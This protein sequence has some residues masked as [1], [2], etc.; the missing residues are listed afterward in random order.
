MKRAVLFISGF[1][2]LNGMGSAGDWPA[3]RGPNGNG[4]AEEKNVPLKW[5]AKTN[6]RWK[7]KLPRPGN[8]SPIVSNG[9][10]FVTCAEDE[11]GTK[12]SLY[13]FD[14]KNGTRLWVRTVEYKEMPTHRT[15]PYCASTPAADG[16]RV[17]VWHGSA[18]LFCYDFEGK[19]L[20]ARKDLGIFRHIWGYASSPVI[21]GDRVIQYCGP[22]K[23]IFVI[24]VELETG[25]TIWKTIEPQQ[26]NGER[27]SE[28][29]YMGSWATP[30]V[31]KIDGKTQ[32]VCSM[33]TRVVSYDPQTGKILWFCEGISG[34][35]GDLAYSSPVVQEN[36]AVA[37]G[38]FRGPA[39]GFKPGGTGNITKTNRLW[40]TPENPQN[41]G[42]GI[43]VGKFL[44]RANA[45][46]KNTV[47]C[48]E[49]TTG[50]LVWRTAGASGCW[51]SIVFVD[52]KMYVTCQNGMTLVFKPNPNKFELLAQNP[53][54]EQCNA[55]PAVSDGNIFI[56]TFD[57]LYCIGE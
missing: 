44:F 8:S 29:K 40:R 15:N 52:G 42:T 11:K 38:G 5:D 27:N 28:G 6:V 48:V 20:W 35:R 12:R 22:G 32:V 50:K 55:T 33:P 46:R 31:A 7:V 17:V 43:L 41:I 57:H 16:K 25:K 19:P 37:I 45:D 54:G 3:F 9:R 39:I 18:G 14:R 34:Q 23:E 13:C 4:V 30:V 10:V 1:L 53:L 51:G 47:D 26:G 21:L 24:A 2:F 56:R 36:L 49:A